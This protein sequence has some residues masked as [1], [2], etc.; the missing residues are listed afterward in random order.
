MKNFIQYI[1]TLSLLI[2]LPV[3]TSCGGGN[4][5]EAPEEHD[6]AHNPNGVQ[7]SARQMKTV[8][9]QFGDF[10]KIKVS[11]FVKA[12][13]TIGLPPI[14]VSSLSAKAAGIISGN[15]KFIEGSFIK[16][17]EVIAYIEN[18]DFIIKQQEY[19]E[20]KALLRYKD[21]ELKR[22]QELV[23]QKAGVAKNLQNAETEFAILEAKTMG[24]QKQLSYIG[25]ST[26]N[27]TPKSIR[28]KI[29]L[30][31]PMSGFITT[32]SLHNGLFVQPE[33]PLM[34]IVSDEHLHLELDV[35]EKDISKI[36]IGQKISYYVPALGKTK[37]EGFVSIVGKEFNRENKT[38]RIHGHLSGNKPMFL[39][40]LFINS[41]IWLND[42]ETLALPEE[43][44]ILDEGSYYIY[45][46]KNNPEADKTEFTKVMVVPGATANGFT[47]VKI[48]Q[49]LPEGMEI[50]V[51]GAY[52][53]YA[54]SKVGI[55]EHDH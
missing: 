24:L 36:K 33:V 12:T 32:I 35:F 5:E 26:K 1:S 4:K 17:G 29:P 43:A 23:K 18:T 22:Q 50:V 15:K 46:A 9:L 31:A 45:I 28:S 54:Q 11:D 16:K 55:L 52:F 34:E 8:D 38:V 14:G 6:H 2:I 53:V 37:Y 48:F 49:E 13:G 44:I 21:L 27:L 7:L 30:T 39:K 41:K 20:S 3:L 40:D 47:T 51:K 42:E 25:I 19:L 10:T